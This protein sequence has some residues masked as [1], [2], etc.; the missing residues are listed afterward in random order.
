M[1]LRTPLLLAVLAAFGLQDAPPLPQDTLPQELP[2]E[3]P[4]G[5]PEE[6]AA[7]EGNGFTRE[8]T[9]LG[10]RL[11]F[12]PVLSLDRTVACASCHQPEHGFADPRRFSLG[13]GGKLT[14]RNSPTLFNRGHATLQMWDGRAASLEEQALMPLENP[15]EMALPIPD[16]L[17]RLRADD[18]Y[19]KAFGRAYGELSRETLAKAIAQFVRR[20]QKGDSPIDR[21]RVG[22]VKDLSK[23]ER[24]GM[25]LFE[26]RAG[27][28]KCHSGPNFSDERFHSTGV[29]AVDGQAEPARMAITGDPADRGRFK[30]A[31]L[32]VLE[33][34]APYM[35]DGS[36]ATLEEVV[37]FYSQGGTPHATR[38]PLLEPFEATPE[39]RKAL[40]AFL[41]ALSRD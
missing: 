40:V 25:W 14:K 19:A 3:A 32:R 2:L 34:T 22:G 29:G 33:L 12:D 20:L 1:S 15:D 31:S 41:R 6:I 38:D 5:F 17:A 13:V 18:F 16:A 8:R 7:P 27:C 39:E 4:L 28:W 9:E 10:R 35:H 36:L 21:F 24:T 26:S 11:F 23:E 30:T 37:D